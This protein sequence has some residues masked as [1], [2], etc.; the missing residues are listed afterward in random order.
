[1]HDAKGRINVPARMRRNLAPEPNDTF[2]IVR[3]FDPCVN[4]YPADEFVHF[5]AKLR[6]LSDGDPDARE[7]VRGIF[8]TAHEATLDAQ[9][10]LNIP[11]GLLKHAGVS[12]ES[13]LVAN[14]NRLELWHPK[15]YEKHSNSLD[16]NRF[17]DFAKRYL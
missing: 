6:E 10:R 17:S 7:F 1:M 12:K 16:S 8:A 15:T 5:D 3:S 4:L 13:M 11:E 14:R 9:G 2:I